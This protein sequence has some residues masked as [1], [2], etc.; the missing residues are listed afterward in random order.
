ML[1]TLRI[2]LHISINGQKKNADK[3]QREKE[4]AEEE[5]RQEEAERLE[6]LGKCAWCGRQNEQI[7]ANQL[8]FP[9]R[10]FCSRKCLFDCK[11]AENPTELS[12]DTPRIT[13]QSKGNVYTSI[14]DAVDDA[15]EGDTL[16]FSNGVF[17]INEDYDIQKSLTFKASNNNMNSPLH[18]RTVFKLYDKSFSPIGDNTIIDGIVFEGKDKEKF[19]YVF[20]WSYELVI[21]NCVFMTMHH[22]ISFI[23]DTTIK[24]ENSLFINCSNAFRQNG[25]Y[26]GE[27]SYIK[28]TTFDSVKYIFQEKSIDCLRNCTIKKSLLSPHYDV[29]S[30]NALSYNERNKKTYKLLQTAIDEA[31]DGDTIVLTPGTQYQGF[32]LEGKNNITIKGAVINTQAP[33]SQKSVVQVDSIVFIGECKGITFEGI[34]FKNLDRYNFNAYQT[35]NIIFNSCE[36]F[37]TKKDDGS[38]TFE[39][40]NKFVFYSCVFNNF[41]NVFENHSVRNSSCKFN[42]C[43]VI[44]SEA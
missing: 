32:N 12:S 6:K 39:S 13:L 31:Y 11:N 42:N 18:E 2:V 23:E 20:S 17:E 25:C 9:G 30:N 34:S 15:Q 10:K 24:I 8:L 41:K 43:D 37:T 33:D 44:Y 3:E 27:A 21:K 26:F 4:E 14:Q 22:A 7:Y 35:E 19:V 29:P 5:R 38:L 28:D 36:F 16:V 1:L 40:E